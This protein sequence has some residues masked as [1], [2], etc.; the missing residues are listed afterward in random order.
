[1][2][3]ASCHYGMQAMLYIACHSVNGSN[4][5]LNKIAENQQIPKHFLS[6]ILQLLVK[7]KLLISMKGPTGGYR[8]SKDPENISLINVVE[9]IDGLRAFEECG[10]FNRPCDAHDP[11]PVHDKFRAFMNNIL[12]LYQGKKLQNFHIDDCECTKN[13]SN[14]IVK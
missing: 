3:S 12:D 5:D 9:A 14:F 2:F 7:S 11:C 6:K 8:L 13:L 4:V 10:V 1:M